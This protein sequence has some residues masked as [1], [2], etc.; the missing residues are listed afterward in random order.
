M[1]KTEKATI[2]N[3]SMDFV[4]FPYYV[5]IKSSSVTVAVV[6]WNAD[7]RWVVIVVVVTLA[8]IPF[9][10]D[11]SMRKYCEFDALPTHDDKRACDG[12]KELN[13]DFNLHR[14]L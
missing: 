11:D 5:F 8:F 3:T 14:I 10:M 9:D 6:M 13:M 4:Q 7:Q 12:N 2:I 1:R